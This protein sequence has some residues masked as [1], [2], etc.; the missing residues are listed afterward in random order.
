MAA[1]F[2]ANDTTLFSN[3]N[4]TTPRDV[5]SSV[6]DATFAANVAT[7]TNRTLTGVVSRLDWRS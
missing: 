6:E 1:N 7:S 3:R 5:T 4:Y 2:V